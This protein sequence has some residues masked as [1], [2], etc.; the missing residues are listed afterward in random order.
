MRKTIPAQQFCFIFL[1]SVI[2]LLI[3]VIGIGL[4]AFAPMPVYKLEFVT[5][6]GTANVYVW[7]M[8]VCYYP[9]EGPATTFRVDQ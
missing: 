4:G 9:V 5:F 7:I 2:T 6:Y 3:A 1:I 8:A